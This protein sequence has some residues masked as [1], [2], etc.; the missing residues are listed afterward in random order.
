M[1]IQGAR[2]WDPHFFEVFLAGEGSARFNEYLGPRSQLIW[3]VGARSTLDLPDVK[4][5]SNE[6]SRKTES[7]LLLPASLPEN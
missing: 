1:R 6:V 4:R 7:Q 5:V 3:H 2:P